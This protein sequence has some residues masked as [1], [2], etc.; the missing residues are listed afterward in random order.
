MAD[1]KFTLEE[2]LSEYT[3]DGK[4][5]GIQKTDDRPLAHGKLET[6]KLLNAA[7]SDR[8]MPG[9]S[10]GY[11]HVAEQPPQ[12]E[13]ELVDIKSTIS[14]IKAAQSAQRAQEAA[15]SPVMRERFPTQSLQREQVSFVNAGNARAAG[16]TYADD[17]ISA[18]D[19]AVKVE[20]DVSESKN[21][22]RPNIRQMA[23]STRAREKKQKKRRRKK[24]ADASYAKESMTGV[25]Q[26][27]D[28]AA[29]A[30]EPTSHHN[31][32]EEEDFY[33]QAQKESSRSG[34]APRRIRTRMAAEETTQTTPDDMTQVR[35]TLLKLRNVVLLRCLALLLLT[36]FG[37]LLAFGEN[38]AGGILTLVSSHLSLRSYAILQLAMGVAGGAIAFP[39]VRSGLWNLLRLHANSDSMAVLPLL[40]AIAGAVLAVISP[41][42]LEN[43]T[44]HLF[45]PC[46]LLALFCNAVGRVL[47]V[48]RA[49]RSCNV[50][51][52]LE[53]KRV[54]SYISQEETAD[55]LTRGLI[56]D[57]PVVTSVRKVD[58]LC[59]FLRYTYSNDLTDTLCRP[60]TALYSGGSLV[61]AV[62]IS[63]I[64]M[65]V[66]FNMLWFSFFLSLLTALLTAG[67]C[68]GS[69]LVV[70]LPLER[71]SKKAAASNSVMLGYQ[72]VDDFYDTNALLAEASDLFP[73]G[74]IRIQ[75]LKVFSGAKVDNVLLDAASLVYR[76]GSILKFAFA[77]MIPER[78]QLH[79][80]DDFVYEDGLGLCGW[81]AN[82]RVLFGGREMMAEHKVEGLPTKTR[83]AELAEG[84]G[85]VL[86]L[87]ISGVLSAMFC[88]QITADPVVKKQMQA[89]KQENIALVIR[90]MDSS[91]SLRRLSTLFQFPEHLMKIL[92]ASMHNLFQRETADLGCVSASMVLGD[93][94]FGAARLLVGSRKVR[95][96][97]VTGMILQVVASLLGLS[98]ALIHVF[99]GAY[100]EINAQF[101][102]LY[103]LILTA[104]T[105]LAVRIR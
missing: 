4:R 57:Y 94:G 14:H 48:R 69:A 75:G 2:I 86:Y 89:L 60:M 33:Y 21:R 103:H 22:H 45:L 34:S 24:G 52:R 6:E 56:S 18:Y 85:D 100:S 90:S 15:A 12:P 95:R 23:D 73:K 38:A 44:I 82:R 87:S 59:D 74:S 39:T 13:E 88:V 27:P 51:T 11:R 7:T 31:W 97:A 80:V 55:L 17:G 37:G 8:P 65:G 105:A 16:N 41:Q 67:C 83:E 42:V 47:V 26:R 63:L 77:E 81:I 32:E 49:M 9:G 99:T 71:E 72:S 102:F 28:S 98:L 92:P 35:S 43:E 93:S 62:G 101:F 5:S 70:N 64:R 50:M 61:V 66:S 40:P 76:A 96:S 79:Q 19:G 25:F 78:E 3:P 53:Q 1:Q 29:G 84:N 36:V 30:S 20:E 46:A 68:V 91:V 54:L 58:S 104:I 10:G